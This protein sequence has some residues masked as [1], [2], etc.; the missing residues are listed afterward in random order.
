MTIELLT[1][2][3]RPV[4]FT[5]PP[6]YLRAV[7][8]GLTDL[9]PW[10][11]FE[12]SRIVRYAAEMG[13]RYPASER[14]PFA[15]RQDK[16]DVACFEKGRPGQVVLVH[17]GAAAGSEVRRVFPDFWSWFRYAVDEMIEWEP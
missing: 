17:D 2:D 6:P 8:Q 14:L 13:G 1:E 9:T 15:K 3:E 11:F 16:D 5:Y 10:F 4:W 12:R 7:S